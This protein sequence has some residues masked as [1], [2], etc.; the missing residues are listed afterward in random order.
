MPGSRKR[1]APG[2]SPSPA[3]PPQQMQQQYVPADQMLQ[4]NTAAT[5]GN[6]YTD[7]SGAPLNHY[8]VAPQ[9]QQG[10]VVQQQQQPSNAIA[11]RQNNRALVPTVPRPTVEAWSTFPDEASR[12]P[13]SSEPLD[14]EDNIEA[15]EEKAKRV[16]KESRA[17]RKQIAPF[18]QKLSRYVFA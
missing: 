3:I 12:A 18:V 8:M 7:A 17:K 16:E 9:A 6:G 14:D 2:A 10:Q 5:N 15:L 1:A 4:W 13:A 11:R